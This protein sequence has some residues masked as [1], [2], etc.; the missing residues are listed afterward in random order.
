MSTL[1]WRTVAELHLHEKLIPNPNA[2]SELMDKLQNVRVAVEGGFL[3]I[4]PRRPGDSPAGQE[5]DVYIVPALAVRTITYRESA[6]RS[7]RVAGF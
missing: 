5:F 7:G 3:H 2:Q 4:D 6:K 1:D